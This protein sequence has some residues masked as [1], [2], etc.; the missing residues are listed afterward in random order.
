MIV[1]KV[2]DPKNRKECGKLWVIRNSLG[3]EKNAS[4]KY[5]FKSSLDR[6]L[7]NGN[8]TNFFICCDWNAVYHNWFWHGRHNHKRVNIPSCLFVIFWLTST[9]FNR[10]R[11]RD[12]YFLQSPKK[13]RTRFTKSRTPNYCQQLSHCPFKY[14]SKYAV[15]NV[16]DLYV[17][18][19]AWSTIHF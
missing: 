4:K 3:G 14:S 17:S 15:S 13:K 2:E 5:L 1:G 18:R 9:D 19:C 7:V 6:H 11:A 10:Y 16:F 8:G 12:F